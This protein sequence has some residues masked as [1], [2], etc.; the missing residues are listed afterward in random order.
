MKSVLISSNTPVYVAGLL[1]GVLP[2]GFCEI[3]II[4][5]ILSIPIIFLNLP[6][7]S[8]ELFNTLETC[9]H[10]ISLINVDLPDPDTPVIQVNVPSGISTSMFFKLCSAAPLIEIFL[11]FPFLLFLGT[12]IHFLRFK[13]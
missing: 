10:S 9:L 12:S 6:G 4:L 8:L 11:P 13:C 3:A 7:F 1:R 2:I 5:S